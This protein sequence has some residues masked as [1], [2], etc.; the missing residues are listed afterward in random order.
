MSVRKRLIDTGRNARAASVSASRESAL[1]SMSA[2]TACCKRRVSSCQSAQR[3]CSVIGVFN[4]A[5]YI[6]AQR[7]NEEGVC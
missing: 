3:Y 2:A 6:S 7:D 1:S 5:K 4:H